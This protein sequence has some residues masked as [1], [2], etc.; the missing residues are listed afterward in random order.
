MR[1]KVS[2]RSLG[3]LRASPRMI[4][5]PLDAS[6]LAALRIP[7][8]R[9]Q[10]PSYIFRGDSADSKRSD[11]TQSVGNLLNRQAHD[12][13]KRASDFFHYHIAEILNSIRPRFI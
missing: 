10:H 5:M 3:I 11:F 8:E 13:F 2:F 4:Q 12:V 1:T 7:C 6:S 9:T